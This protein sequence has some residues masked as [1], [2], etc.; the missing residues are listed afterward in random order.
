MLQS[1][2]RLALRALL[3]IVSFLATGSLAHAQAQPPPIGASAQVVDANNRL[4]AVA[5]FRQASDQVLINLTFPDRTSLSGTHG[6]QIHDV[7]RCDPPTFATAGGIF[8]PFGKQHGLLNP[9]GPM[10]GDLPSLV[11]G[12]SGVSTYNLSAPLVTL[13]TGTAA[14]L[15]PQGTSLV[16]FANADDDT[17]Q[18]EGNAG[19]RIACGVI[20]NGPPPTTPPTPLSA[21]TGGQTGFT[22]AVLIAGVGA[23][24]IAAGLLLRRQRTA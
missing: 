4:L 15:R 18:P 2:S 17:S 5:T 24:L 14:L 3:A 21:A 16:I 20:V 7:G 8:N 13:N 10:A 23:L 9:N 19:T 12:T 22:G 1:V 6:I 11:I